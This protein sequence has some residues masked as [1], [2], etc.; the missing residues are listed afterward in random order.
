M[1]GDFSINGVH[2]SKYGLRALDDSYIKSA[3]PNIKQTAIPNSSDVFDTTEYGGYV[4]YGRGEIYTALGGVL[5]SRDHWPSKESEIARLCNGKLCTL[6]FDNDPGYYYIGRG[7]VE[8]NRTRFRAASIGIKW[9]CDPYKYELTDGS[10]QQEWDTVDLID[11]VFREYEPTV[12]SGSEIFE[13]IAR[14]KP[15]AL[16]IEIIDDGS[17]DWPTNLGDIYVSHAES[18]DATKWYDRTNIGPVPEYTDDSGVIHV[19]VFRPRVTLPEFL[20]GAGTTHYVKVEGNCTVQMHYR[21]G[22]LY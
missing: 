22:V 19:S 9:T 2:I 3:Q 16:E 20:F 17:E 6:T 21:G 7:T 13:I 8:P 4:S 11:G 1:T 10:E 5:S 12:V 18:A 14:D 15:V